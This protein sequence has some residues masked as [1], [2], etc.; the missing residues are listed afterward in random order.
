MSLLEEIVQ[1][2]RLEV[3]ELRRAAA[4]SAA[5]PGA[6]SD[7]CAGGVRGSGRVVGEVRDVRAALRRPAGGRLRL[8]AEVKL[9]S[10]SAGTLSADTRVAARAA[11]YVE[12]GAAMVSVLTD[13]KWFGG[14]FAHLTEVRQQVSVPVLCKDF[15]IDPIQVRRA[16]S[17]GADA[18]LVIVRCVPQGALLGELVQAACEAG[19]EPFVEVFSEAELER[20]LSAGA[21]VVGVNARDLDTLKMDA[22][23]AARV[24]AAIPDEV[25]AVHLSGLRTPQDAARIARSR[26]DAALVGETLMRQADPRPLLTAMA[27]AAG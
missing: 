6:T 23:R 26:A 18:A 27:A 11:A 12:A 16:W 3:A 9:R 20:A 19:I 7:G 15:P 10:P 14:C 4:E 5:T 25:V 2:K 24:L 17:A 1:Q 21:R 22:E 13:T 8:I